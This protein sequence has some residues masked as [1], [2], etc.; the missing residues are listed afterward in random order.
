[1]L[2]LLH[3]ILYLP[4]IGQ[5]TSIKQGEREGL[6]ITINE[7]NNSNNQDTLYDSLLINAETTTD[8][9]FSIQNDKALLQELV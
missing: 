6:S 3:P 1:M 4:L 7:F 2:P 8:S 5:Q 9:H